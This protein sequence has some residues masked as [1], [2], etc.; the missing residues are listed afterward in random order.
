MYTD[1]TILIEAQIAAVLGVSQQMISRE[2]AAAIARGTSSSK[3]SAAPASVNFTYVPL[4]CS[5]SQPLAIARLSPALYS[6]G[7]P[8]N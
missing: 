4:S 1:G 5:H 6:A 7:V 2:N 8:F 3:T